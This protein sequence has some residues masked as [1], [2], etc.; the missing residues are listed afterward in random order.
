M[1][2]VPGSYEDEAG[3]ELTVKKDGTVTYKTEVS[4][5]INGSPMSAKLTFHGE[6]S[7]QGFVFDKVT[8]MGIDLT[9]IAAANG[10]TDASPWQTAAWQM[11]L[12]QMK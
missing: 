9:A 4:G 7:G 5:K 2:I 10:L 6:V 3:S 11:Y 12:A 1:E 8:Y